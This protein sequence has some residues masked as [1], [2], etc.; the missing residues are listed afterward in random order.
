MYQHRW[1]GFVLLLVGCTVAIADDPPANTPERKPDVWMQKKLKYSQQVLEGIAAGDFDLIAKSGDTL[2]GMDKIES[3]IRARTPRYRLQLQLFQDANDE[4]IRQAEA[5]N[6][7]GVTLAF[8]QLTISCVN[9][10]KQL[11]EEIRKKKVDR[12]ALRP[13]PQRSIRQ[14]VANP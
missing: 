13:L 9:C 8:N 10:H 2:K 11:R 1:A 6:L 14:I 5:E 12:E 3:F 4:I 7:E